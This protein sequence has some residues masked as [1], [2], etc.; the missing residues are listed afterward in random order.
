MKQLSSFGI[1]LNDEKNNTFSTGQSHLQIL[2]WNLRTLYNTLVDE[3][4]IKF[5]NE[6]FLH[7][8]DKHAWEISIFGWNFPKIKRFPNVDRQAQKNQTGSFRSEKTSWLGVNTTEQA[9]FYKW[10]K[11]RLDAIIIEF[12]RFFPNWD[13]SAV[14]SSTEQFSSAALLEMGG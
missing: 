13:C 9:F 1:L 2:T 11:F 10:C 4:L 12:S 14:K 8:H 7:S 3:K 5:Q 6:L